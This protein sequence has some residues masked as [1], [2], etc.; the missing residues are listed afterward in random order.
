MRVTAL[1]A[2]AAA[3]LLSVSASVRADFLLGMSVTNELVGPTL[4]W[5]GEASSTY[6]ALGAYQAKTGYEIDNLTG[7]I[8]HRRYVGGSFHRRSFYGDFFVGDLGG[9]PTYNRVGAG[10]AVGHQWVTENLRVYVSAGVAVLGEASGTGGPTTT[11][12]EPQSILGA[13]ASIRY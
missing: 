3:A 4:E 1:N 12:P 9:G 7:Y 5:A 8:G 13:G 2:L 10:G 6:L 11:D